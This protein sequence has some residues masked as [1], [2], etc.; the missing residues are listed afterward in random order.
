M[1][2]LLDRLLYL[3]YEEKRA[4]VLILSNYFTQVLVIS[5]QLETC[6]SRMTGQSSFD[7]IIEGIGQ[8]PIF[9]ISNLGSKFTLESVDSYSDAFGAIRS[10][11][12]HVWHISLSCLDNLC[13]RKGLKL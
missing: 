12:S 1:E 6:Q 9:S 8:T 5:H 3:N 10:V 11:P 2:L 13:V 4:F 7:V